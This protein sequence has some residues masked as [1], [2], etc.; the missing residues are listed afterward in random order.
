MKLTNN[1]CKV[2]L[3]KSKD[4]VT[5][6]MGLSWLVHA[7]RDF[8]VKKM[9]SNEYEKGSNRD[10]TFQKNNVGGDDASGRRRTS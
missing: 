9:I 10:R 4:A 6:K 2:E 1:L 5:G 7:V 3:K 8:G